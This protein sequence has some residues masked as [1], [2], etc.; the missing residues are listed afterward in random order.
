MPLEI[1][2]KLKVESHEEMRARLAA[3]GAEHVGMVRETNMFFDRPDRGLRKAD[4]GLRVR[5]TTAARANAVAVLSSAHQR[6]W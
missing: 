5:L 4:S 6:F 2:I 3:L 1:E